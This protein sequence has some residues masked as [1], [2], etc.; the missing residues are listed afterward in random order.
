MACGCDNNGWG[1]CG[2]GNTVQYAPS[3]C[4]S[5]FPTTCTALGQGVIQRVVGEDSGS[6]KYTIPTFN[7]NSLLSYNA[8][9]GLVNWADGSASNPI[10][11][12]SG[13]QVSSSTVGAIQGT[14][15]TGQLVEFN[16]STSAETQFPIV[17][18]SGVTTTWGTIENIIPSQG[19][20]YKNASNVVVQ[21]PLGTA[22]QVLT[23][24]GGVPQF[25]NISSSQYI[26][27]QSISTDYATSTSLTV[28]Y[29]SLV[30]NSLSTGVAPIV[31]NGSG[32]P[33][34]LNTNTTGIGNM[35]ASYNTAGY[36]YVYAIYNPTTSTLNVIGSSSYTLPSTTYLDGY[37]YYRLI[38]MFYM[39]SSNVVASGFF[40]NG[41]Y[42]YLGQSNYIPVVTTSTSSVQYLGGP[43]T[44][45]PYQVVSSAV[46][47]IYNAGPSASGAV[48]N[49][50]IASTQ[51]YGTAGTPITHTAN[52]GVSLSSEFYGSGAFCGIGM[53]NTALYSD[54][55]CAI[56]IASSAY[57]NVN[58][59]GYAVASTL[60]IKAYTLS[61][62]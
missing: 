54:F 23:M 40:Q 5:N 6:C 7:S 9:T 11:L 56:P 20:V 50:V 4:N 52:H 30:L 14:T 60:Y 36:Y 51:A 38:G 19:I 27:A 31:K 21:A 32:T 26:D 10:F 35:D 61:I 43:I 28:N 42:V 25:G 47:S 17:S 48:V 53:V 46:F 8:S 3:V 13:N 34:T 24:V 49:A 15:P 45:A 12:G 16:P 57:Y 55:S 22:G 29:G 1:G 2:C 58:L 33:F 59:P 37:T 41:R 39:T 62:F 44:F 18:P